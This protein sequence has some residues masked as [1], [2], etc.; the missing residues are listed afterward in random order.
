[1]P[2]RGDHQ[3]QFDPLRPRLNLESLEGIRPTYEDRIL[4]KLLP[5]SDTERGLHIPESA[6]QKRGPQRGLVI[7]VGGGMNYT[8]DKRTGRKHYFTER[9]QMV[10]Q[11]GDEVLVERWQANEFEIDGETYFFLFEEQSVLGVFE[12]SKGDLQ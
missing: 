6:R 10:V 2:K 12:N 4:V 8:T 11:P 5:Q 1:M 3:S 7:A 9:A